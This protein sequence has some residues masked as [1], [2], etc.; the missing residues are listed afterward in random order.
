MATTVE[1][2]LATDEK[3]L[4]NGDLEAALERREQKKVVKRKV[5][6]EFR[7]ADEAVKGLL[8]PFDLSDGE[9]ARCGKFRIEVR[10]VPGGARSFETSD[11]TR[12]LISADKTQL[13][14]TEEA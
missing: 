7:E 1:P 8:L 6:K 3:P 14:I 4:E 2:Q 12:I 9:V 11:S 13:E 10:T 5:N